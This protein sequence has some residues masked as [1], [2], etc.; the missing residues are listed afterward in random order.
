[1]SPSYA[2]LFLCALRHAHP[3]GPSVL[4]QTPQATLPCLV[5]RT[6]AKTHTEWLKIPCLGAS[7]ANDGIFEND[8]R[9]K[10]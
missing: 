8:I 6:F 4:A 7:K 2:L 10:T 1:M 3:L 9:S 5:A